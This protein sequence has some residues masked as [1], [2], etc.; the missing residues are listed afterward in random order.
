MIYFSPYPT[1]SHKLSVAYS[2]DHTRTLLVLLTADHSLTIP[3]LPKGTPTPNNYRAPSY[4]IVVDGRQLY[5]AL[6]RTLLVVQPFCESWLEDERHNLCRVVVGQFVG[7]DG[8]FFIFGCHGCPD[9]ADGAHEHSN[10]AYGVLRV[11]ALYVHP[12]LR[13]Y[14]QPDISAGFLS[15][16]ETAFLC[17]LVYPP[18]Y[19]DTSTPLISYDY[20]FNHR[21]EI[22]LP[23]ISDRDSTHTSSD[24]NSERLDVDGER[25][26]SLSPSDGCATVSDS[27]NTTNY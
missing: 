5:N 25:T 23:A 19:I 22:D 14:I 2:L 8:E 27:G 26:L 16:I 9:Y 24:T 11:H 15:H 18:G 10:C 1:P 20:C 6:P 4:L 7:R 13:G 12:S 3:V 21:Y 17:E